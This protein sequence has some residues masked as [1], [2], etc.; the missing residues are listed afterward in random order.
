VRSDSSPHYQIWSIAD[1]TR[2]AT[3]PYNIDKNEETIVASM[4]FDFTATKRLEKP[5]YPDENPADCA[6]LPILWVLNTEG[7]LAG[8]TLLYVPG[9]VAGERPLEMRALEKQDQYWKQEAE[10]RRKEAE[11][12]G[13]Q[14]RR[15]RELWEKVWQESKGGETIQTTSISERSQP[16]NPLTETPTRKDPLPPSP[17]SQSQIA[18]TTLTQ[19]S[20]PTFGQ[21]SQ[22]GASTFGRPTQL[23]GIIPG[24]SHGFGQNT[25]LS[26]FT[27]PRTS[28]TGPIGF[29]R[30]STTPLGQDSST[31]ATQS[32]FL[33]GGTPSSSFLSAA[34]GGSF[35]QPGQSS[36]FLSGTQGSS[37]VKPGQ[38]QGFAKFTTSTTPVA[39]DQGFAKYATSSFRGLG[40]PQNMTTPSSFSE[41]GFLG[42]RPAASSTPS[43]FGSL[44]KGS[45][46]ERT[47]S[48]ASLSSRNQSFDML[49]DSSSQ[50]DSGSD[51]S[52]VNESEE[53]EGDS[54]VRVDALSFGD[55]LSLEDPRNSSATG[56]EVATPV[57]KDI[58]SPEQSPSS[59]GEGEYV[60]VGIPVTPSPEKG[61][62]GSDD[63][64]DITP[65]AREKSRATGNSLT[66]ITSL[67]KEPRNENKI[68]PTTIS[69]QKS[70][71]V[72]EVAILPPNPF[73]TPSHRPSK[74]TTSP[75]VPPLSKDSQA[76]SLESKARAVSTTRNKVELRQFGSLSGSVPPI[77]SCLPESAD[78]SDAF[79][80]VVEQ[81]SKEL[82][83]VQN[84][85]ID[86]PT[87]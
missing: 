74:P 77:S 15:D 57:T 37:F 56:A 76:S 29:A 16:E 63:I 14:E 80:L 87:N 30:Y 54:N 7:Q 18:M 17:Q 40:I 11:Q 59:V 38:D 85:T 9:I 51:E 5:L 39:Q 41:G 70:T 23:G 31:H 78:L 26:P 45:L 86:S 24:Q 55:S 58:D 8:W 72:V 83:K 82:A 53:S 25:G 35:L 68:T 61:K 13:D 22:L 4:Q 20:Q 43:P 71:P 2:R 12:V 10:T 48:L 36:S 34:K 47:Q 81:V 65:S 69:S 49:E 67:P 28:T 46:S 84:S 19:S 73:L 33:S 42:T 3:V 32:A 44:P 21:P 52:D 60:K 75:V 6:A 1:A 79:R 62:L 64:N 66:T 50:E 27:T